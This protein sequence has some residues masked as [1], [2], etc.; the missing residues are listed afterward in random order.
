MKRETS[1]ANIAVNIKQAVVKSSVPT[2]ATRAD[3]EEC[4][5][6]DR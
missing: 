5:D 6:Y 4:S 3:F 2:T 1:A